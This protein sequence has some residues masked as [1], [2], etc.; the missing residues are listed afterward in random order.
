MRK[1]SLHQSSLPCG[2]L[3]SDQ[4]Q[5]EVYRVES[6]EAVVNLSSSISLI[7]LYCSWLPADG[8]VGSLLPLFQFCFSWFISTKIKYTSVDASALCINLV[9]CCPNYN[10]AFLGL[11]L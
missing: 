5:E 9:H 4:F 8:L 2:P 3:E 7:Y 1:E 10:F 6:T 11:F